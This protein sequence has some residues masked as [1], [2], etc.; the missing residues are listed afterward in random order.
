M[1]LRNPGEEKTHC[2]TQQ[3]PYCSSW[4]GGVAGAEGSTNLRLEGLH[5]ESPNPARV[6]G[7]GFMSLGLRDVDKV[8]VQYP[9]YAGEWAVRT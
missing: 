8:V 5:Q 1:V 6:W 4:D 2:S 9:V 3:V 7:A